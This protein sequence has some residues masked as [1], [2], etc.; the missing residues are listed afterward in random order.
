MKRKLKK[1]MPVRGSAVW[2]GTLPNMAQRNIAERTSMCIIQYLSVLD[3]TPQFIAL[4]P[5]QLRVMGKDWRG[6]PLVEFREAL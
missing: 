6:I 2:I 3:H 1:P 4:Y 5:D